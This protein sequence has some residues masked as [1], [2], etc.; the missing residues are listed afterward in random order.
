MST[1]EAWRHTLTEQEAMVRAKEILAQV[2]ANRADLLSRARERRSQQGQA[3]A[4]QPE[5]SRNQ[6]QNPPKVDSSD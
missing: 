3:K 5:P 2:K 4:S 1:W 6:S